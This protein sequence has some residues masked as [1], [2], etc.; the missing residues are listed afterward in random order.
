MDEMILGIDL[1]TTNSEVAIVKNGQPHVLEITHGN[2]ILPSVVAISEQNELLVG[3]QARNQQIA[4]P[5]RT[6]TSVKRKMGSD[7][8]ILLSGKEYTPQE[9]SGIILKKLKDLAEQHL[10][11]Q[12]TKAVITVPA[13]FS[14]QQRQAT[15]EAGQIAGLEVV[16]MINE[17]TAAALAYEIEQKIEKKILVYDLGGG[18]FDVS[19]VSISEQITEVLSSHGNNHLGGDDFDNKIR[20]H[21][22]THLKE[23]HDIDVT[24]DLKAMVR[25]KHAA[26]IAKIT[27]S[28]APYAKIEEEFIADKDGEPIHL[29]LEISRVYYEALIKSFIDETFAAVNIAMNNANL[30]LSEIDEVILVGG[31]TRTPIIAERFEKELNILP[32][33]NIHPELCV[34]MGAAIQGAVIGGQAV[35]SVL[36]DVTPYT[37]G[38]S[39]LGELDG[40][41]T[42]SMFV[43]IIKKNTPIPV[44]KSESF[45]TVYDAQPQVEIKVYQGDNIDANNNIEIGKFRVSGLSQVPAGNPIILNLHLDINGMLKVTAVEKNTGLVKSV[46]IENV[47]SKFGAT[48][49]IQAK[50][51]VNMLF[52]NY[53]NTIVTNNSLI[54]DA[55]ELIEK[56]RGYLE[57]QNEEDKEDLIALIEQIS[58]AI[59]QVD[60][61]KMQEK[62]T[63]L[64]DLLYYYEV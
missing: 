58:D 30:T 33:S 8:K 35:S 48:E 60:H 56:A 41:V 18:T 3:E 42:D 38:T 57:V 32:K 12:V 19:I 5:E 1:G 16:R 36:I 40:M 49:L 47:I 43:P 23:L 54:K 15:Y 45:F 7:E 29:S 9:I 64:N 20:E 6:I 31:S 39:A 34:A 51:R 44:T 55:Q 50:N 61:A 24:S 17:P 46:T 4:Y 22:I 53:P 14:D 27:L 52:D 11:C 2:F 62:M 26:E 13:Y 37:F 59:E 21:V 10:G 63:E 25:I 28:S